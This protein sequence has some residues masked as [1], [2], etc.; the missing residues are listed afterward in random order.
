LILL[1]PAMLC[2]IGI[3]IC[4]ANLIRDGQLGLWLVI[5]FLLVLGSFFTA[6]AILISKQKGD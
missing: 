6:I 2:G 1:I 5:G 3:L 4:V